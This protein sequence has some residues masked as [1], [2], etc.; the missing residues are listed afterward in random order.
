MNLTGIP[1]RQKVQM[2]ES[3]KLTDFAKGND[4]TLQ[5]EGICNRDPQTTVHCHIRL[6]GIAGVAQKPHD[7]LGFH[8]CS[9]CHRREKEAGYDDI[10]RALMLTQCRIYAEFK[11]LT[12]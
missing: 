2:F 5:L 10:L 8:G 4:C 11:T 1:V 6:F 9:E 12:P 3:K 7:F